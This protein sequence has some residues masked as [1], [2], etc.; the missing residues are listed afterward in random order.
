MADTEGSNVDDQVLNNDPNNLF[1][2][3]HS[4]YPIT[5]LDSPFLT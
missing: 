4:D 2:V 5:A 3:H 1:F